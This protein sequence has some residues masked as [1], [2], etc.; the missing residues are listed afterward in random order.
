MD[1]CT[2]AAMSPTSSSAAAPPL[3]GTL[4]IPHS[5]P[6]EDP[7]IAHVDRTSALMAVIVLPVFQLFE[8]GSSS[9]AMVSLHQG[10][11]VLS[12]QRQHLLDD[13]SPDIPVQP[14]P[15]KPI[16]CFKVWRKW[17]T[18]PSFFP[19]LLPSHCYQTRV[20]KDVGKEIKEVLRT[21]GT[22]F[23]PANCTSSRCIPNP[24]D[25]PQ[26]LQIPEHCLIYFP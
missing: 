23:S 24:D 26:Q 17:C 20:R 6:W 21:Q 12:P 14:C 25:S 5:I 9:P 7:A 22:E 18:D 4:I 16:L 2:H 15:S 13:L 11:S 10:F 3:S 8:H 1:T 19:F